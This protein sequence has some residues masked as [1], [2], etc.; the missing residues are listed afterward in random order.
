MVLPSGAR[1]LCNSSF[2]PG[3]G[4]SNEGRRTIGTEVPP[5]TNLFGALG[6]GNQAARWPCAAG[7]GHV[8]ERVTY[9]RAARI[10][11]ELTSRRLQSRGGLACRGDRLPWR[12]R[13][14]HF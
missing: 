4:A 2:A 10:S 13:P 5:T 11:G 6:V 14:L 1:L 12:S 8:H 7:S 3:Q 9:V